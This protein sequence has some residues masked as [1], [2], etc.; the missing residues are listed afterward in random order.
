MYSGIV[1]GLC[2][3]VA[4]DDEDGIRRLTVELGPLANGLELGASVAVNGVCLSATATDGGRASFD[5]IG[6]T[7]RLTNLG[8]IAAGDLVDVERSMRHGD[9]IG[10]HE[11]SGHVSG[12][13]EITEIDVDRG[14]RTMWFSVDRTWL[15]YLFHKGFIAIDGASLTISA[16]DEERA[17]FA[18]SLIPDTLA[19]TTLG[20]R[21]VG[22]RV[23]IELD[24]RTQAIVRTVERLLADERFRDRGITP[25]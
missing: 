6:E 12:T 22:E 2:E 24:A 23:N 4:V 7:Q 21:E 20:R 18:V 8:T 3:V 10:G 25:A 14:N 11:V 9:E 1:Q 13:A 17:R 5:V 15:P 19:R 16:L